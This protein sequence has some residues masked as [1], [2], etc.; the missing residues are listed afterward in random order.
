MNRVMLELRESVLR[1]RRRMG[2]GGGT[3]FDRRRVGGATVG[4][5][6][7]SDISSE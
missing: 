7:M 1:K 6:L 3:A 4:G 2:D 5:A